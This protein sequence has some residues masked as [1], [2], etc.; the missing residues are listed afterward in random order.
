MIWVGIVG[1]VAVWT[2]WSFLRELDSFEEVVPTGAVPALRPFVSVVVPMRNEETNASRCLH[3]LL[4]Q[5][6]PDLEVIAVD[7]GSTDQTSHILDRFLEKAELLR[8]LRVGRKPEG[9]NGK[10]YALNRASR[11]ARGSW[12]LFLD[13]DTKA[14]PELVCSLVNRV[15]KSPCDMI[16]LCPRQVL[17]SFWERAIQ[18]VVFLIIMRS[19][20]ARKAND[21]TSKTAAANG[22]CIFINR[23]VYEQIGG[24]KAIKGSILDDFSLAGL[25]KERG[26]RLCFADG[27]KLIRTR[28]YKN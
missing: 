18:P 15:A 9:W 12:L 28:M 25:V 6:Y 14:E 5:S 8:V 27:R 17:D 4:G 1:G 3:S 16:S 23:Q 2:W 19:F 26:F 24:H 20:S 7:D 22:Q 13:A 10:S 21:P 11:I